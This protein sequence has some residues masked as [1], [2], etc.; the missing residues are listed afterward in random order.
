[1]LRM[2][3]PQISFITGTGRKTK[4][5]FTKRIWVEDELELNLFTDE[6]MGYGGSTPAPIGEAWR[7]AGLYDPETGTQS[8]AVP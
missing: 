6:F 8:S 3:S 1:M 7:R 2:I 5:N 4:E